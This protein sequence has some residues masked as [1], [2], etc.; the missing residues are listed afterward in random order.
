M[1][2]MIRI[3]L[4][5]RS[6]EVLLIFFFMFFIYIKNIW[7]DGNKFIIHITVWKYIYNPN[8]T[9]FVI[10]LK[11]LLLCNVSFIELFTRKI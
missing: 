10:F 9:G 2:K 4:S 7:Q 6:E 11:K 8:V 3:I 1:D 5:I